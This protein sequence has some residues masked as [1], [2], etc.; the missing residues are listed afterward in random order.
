MS[1]GGMRVVTGARTTPG[2]EELARLVALSGGF[3]GAR[4]VAPSGWM[5]KKEAPWHRRACF[6]HARGLSQREISRSLGKSPQAVCNLAHQSFF[7]ER[8]VAIMTEL[9]DRELREA[10]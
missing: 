2:A 6:M 4:S 9:A 1:V 7:Q 8:F 10:F 5:L 3:R